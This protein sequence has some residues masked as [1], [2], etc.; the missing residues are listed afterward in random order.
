M[1]DENT[2][3]LSKISVTDP[4]YAKFVFATITGVYNDLLN[5][6][7]FVRSNPDSKVDPLNIRL[8][9][10]S[11]T[12]TQAVATISITEGSVFRDN[13]FDELKELSVEFYDF[14]KAYELQMADEEK[15]NA[16][17]GKFKDYLGSMYDL[18]IAKGYNVDSPF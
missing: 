9:T 7:D 8:I 4:E 14:Q 17:T 13:K 11:F 12:L 10:D 3:D 18:L 1:S 2:F 6:K 5:S 16:L 15:F